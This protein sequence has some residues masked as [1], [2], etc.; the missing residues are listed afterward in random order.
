M[1][2]SFAIT[3]L[4][5]MSQK[6]LLLPFNVTVIPL[7]CQ[8]QGGQWACTFSSTTFIHEKHLMCICHKKKGGARIGGGFGWLGRKGTDRK[9]GF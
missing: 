2:Q 4:L 1:G 6:V 5:D 7:H 9:E 3:N 8:T